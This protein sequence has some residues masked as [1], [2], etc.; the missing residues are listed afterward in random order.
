MKTTIFNLRV[1]TALFFVIAICSNIMAQDNTISITVNYL[2]Y[3]KLKTIPEKKSF[4][5]NYLSYNKK[6]YELIHQEIKRENNISLMM[7]W[8]YLRGKV[9]NGYQYKSDEIIESLHKIIELSQGSNEYMVEYIAANFSLEL[10][11]FNTNKLSE[12]ELYSSY[13]KYL[14]MMRSLGFEKFYYYDLDWMLY[15]MGRTFYTLGDYE[16]SLESLKLSIKYNENIHSIFYTLTL[17]LIQAIYAISKE[18]SSAIHYAGLIYEVN[19]KVN[20]TQDVK[21]WRSLYW[22][23]LSSLDIASYYM[24]LNN[25]ARASFYANRGYSLYK[26]FD[27]LNNTTQVIAE[28]DALQVIIK[29]KIRLKKLEEAQADL[30]RAI[31]LQPHIRFEDPGNYFKTLPFYYNNVEYYELKNDYKNAF[32]YLKLANKME[33]SLAKQNDKRKLWQIEMRVDAERYQNQIESVQKN[34]RHE[35]LLK[36][37]AVTTLIVVILLGYLFIRRIKNDN[38][39]IAHQKTLLETSLHDKERLLQEIHHRVKNNLQIISGLFE[40]QARNMKDEQAKKLMKEGQD[41]VYS[42]ALVHQN[43]YQSEDLST[44][45][46]KNFI[47]TL[48]SNIERSYKPENQNIEVKVDIDES[49]LS[50][51]TAI[52][53]G[54][55]V[56]ELIT[57]CYKYAFVNKKIGEIDISFKKVDHQYHLMVADNGVGISGEI[58]LNSRNSLGINLVRGLVRQLE[59][60]FTIE[61]S[62]AGTKAKIVFQAP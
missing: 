23:G 32:K 16:K 51:D 41:R 58:N 14:S 38:L 22:Q 5:K 29:L 55:I 37:L 7:Y 42:I 21:E 34:S 56:N 19:Y 57:N 43:L 15:S 44:L 28:Y 10:H 52:P 39:I 2:D 46:I 3:K 9:G 35:G 60:I 27:D 4:L 30:E 25:L 8:H 18:Y 11:K 26:S 54:L 61:S 13:L 33:D 49:K 17:N 50:I 24:E 47:V 20:P 59:G 48:I 31:Y 12:Q 53:M 6:T 62:E 36:N 1:I 45:G 40:K